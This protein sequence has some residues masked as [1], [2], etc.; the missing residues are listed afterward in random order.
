MLPVN[1]MSS[2]HLDGGE[3]SVIRSLGFG[4]SPISGSDLKTR[5]PGL[6]EQELFE[7]LETLVALGYICSTRE[8]A[9]RDEI[10]RSTFFINPGYSRELKD[11]LDPRPRLRESRR[12]R[13]E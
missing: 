7:I 1:N 8:L 9:R 10:D 4:G 13:R 5:V 2:I 3:T 6:G 11:A 12:V